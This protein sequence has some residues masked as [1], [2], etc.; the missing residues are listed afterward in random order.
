MKILLVIGIV[1][2]LYRLCMSISH[3]DSS[4]SKDNVQTEDSSQSKDDVQTNDSFKRKRVSVPSK[5]CLI[6]NSTIYVKKDEFTKSVVV[7]G[8]RYGNCTSGFDF[9]N[10]YFEFENNSGKNY[11]LVTYDRKDM[12]L[13]KK[14]TLHILLSNNIVITTN[15]IAKPV[16]SSDSYSTMKFPLSYDE[17]Q[18]METESLKKWRIINE[19]SVVIKSGTAK[20]YES[21]C[22]YYCRN[23]HYNCYAKVIKDFIIKF[24][25]E[26]RKNIPEEELRNTK[27]DIND[28]DKNDKGT[29]YVY[30]MI[31]TTNNFYKI[32]IS[33]NPRYREHT[34]QSDKPTIELICAKEYPSR[35]IAEAIESALH[36]AYANKRIRGEWFN[37]EDNDIIEIKQTL[38]S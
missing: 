7:T 35:T 13:D 14:C 1:Y 38:K 21:T 18:K 26:I 25:D 8:E 19:A 22:M 3:Q 2:G 15:P 9:G 30:L 16:K 11:I 36:K 37:L 32:G 23:K 29:C 12:T 33:N 5:K 20:L 17:I 34:L 10:I 24:N 6:K 28:T 4:E 31:D 27:E